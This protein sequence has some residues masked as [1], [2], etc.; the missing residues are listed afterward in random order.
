V[1]DLEGFLLERLLVGVEADTDGTLSD[2]VHLEHLVLLVIDDVLFFV[3]AVLA[4]LEAEGD[5]VQELAVLVLLRIEEEAE[6]V[7]H[8]VEEVVHDERAFDLAG[9]RC[10]E[11]VAS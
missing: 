10:Q 6:V 3:V 1:G 4:W 11:L 7:E 9:Q 2:E 8:V 5:I